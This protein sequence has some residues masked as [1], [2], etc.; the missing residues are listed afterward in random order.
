MNDRISTREQC[1][2]SL[3]A[4]VEEFF[5]NGYTVVPGVFTEDEVATFLAANER[6][7]QKVR[8]TPERFVG[9]RYTARQDGQ[10]DTWG[11]N[12]IFMP[13]LY[14]PELAKIFG[15]HGFM[16]PVHAILG[17]RLRF[18]SAH[19]LWSPHHVDYEL[20]WH[21]D[22]HEHEHYDPDGKPRHVQFNVCL[23]ED[24][25]F[26]AIP[27]SHRRPLTDRERAEI[28]TLGTGRMPGEVVVDCRPGDVIYMNYHMVHRGSCRAGVFRRTLHMNVQS[29][30]E[31]TGGQTSLTWMRDP[32]Y[33]DGVEPA[34][35]ALM[36]NAIAWDDSHP[37]GRAEARRRMRV[38]QD[39][40]RHVAGPSG[41]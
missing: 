40:R 5:T 21:K 33:L 10:V 24:N 30:E 13:D 11:V 16:E 9:S 3:D 15:H 39:V 34:L 28:E 32:E 31:P 17:P 19:S 23:S 27:G 35:A 2:G 4:H 18:W 22:N 8:S 6:I 20:N 38:R 14:E 41:Q 37:I 1:G 36:R 7:V 29:Q 12:N 26:H 25:S